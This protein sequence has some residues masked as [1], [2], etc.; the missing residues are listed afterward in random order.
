MKQPLIQQTL[1][2]FALDLGKGKGMTGSGS[3]AAMSSLMGSQLLLSVCKITLSKD[4]YTEVHEW[5]S[6]QIPFLDHSCDTLSV[7]MEKDVE[8]VAAFLK[9]NKPSADMLEAPLG[10]G[11]ESIKVLPIGIELYHKGYRIMKGDTATALALLRAGASATMFI[12]KENLKFL[13]N[14]EQYQNEVVVLEEKA[15]LLCQQ[16]DELLVKK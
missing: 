1:G 4:S 7:L 15:T 9:H 6:K 2:D 14:G 10:I 11:V 8:A 13:G 3:A 16:V 12:V 5:V